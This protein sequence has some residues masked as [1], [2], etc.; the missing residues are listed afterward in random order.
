MVFSHGQ[1][2]IDTKDSTYKDSSME[3]VYFTS[4][5]VEFLRASGSMAKKMGMDN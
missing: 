2:E 5:M 3:R 4:Q 1:M